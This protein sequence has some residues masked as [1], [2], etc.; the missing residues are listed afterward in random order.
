MKKIWLTALLAIGCGPSRSRPDAKVIVDA[1]PVSIDALPDASKRACF[2]N[3]DCPDSESCQIHNNDQNMV[4][5]DRGER[6]FGLLGSACTSERN[7]KSGICLE[8]RDPALLLC[9]DICT[10]DVECP[11]MIPR[12]FPIAGVKICIRQ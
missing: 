11:A 4:Y 1:A 2:T 10:T 6:G 12:C 3:Y 8:T 7:C 9:S 5:C